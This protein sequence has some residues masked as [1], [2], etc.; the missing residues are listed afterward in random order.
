MMRQLMTSLN[1]DYDHK[2]NEISGRRA[3]EQL[4]AAK[5]GR[6]CRLRLGAR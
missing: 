3:S 4:L 1:E 5:I 6:S 2:L